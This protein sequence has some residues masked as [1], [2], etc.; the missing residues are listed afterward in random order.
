MTFEERQALYAELAKVLLEK[1][2]VDD[3]SER[4][5]EL[6]VRSKE[7]QCT[8]LTAS[9]QFGFARPEQADHRKQP[10]RRRTG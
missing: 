9:Q 7:L 10:R 5:I 3:G 1:S 4:F 6:D 8:L 2:L